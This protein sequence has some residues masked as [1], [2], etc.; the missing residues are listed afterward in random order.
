MVKDAISNGFRLENGQNPQKMVTKMVM[1]MTK[2][3]QK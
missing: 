1:R 3:R 2:N